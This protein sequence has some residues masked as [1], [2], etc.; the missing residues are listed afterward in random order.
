[1][2][3]RPCTRCGRDAP[4]MPSK[5]E[6]KARFMIL[7]THFTCICGSLQKYKSIQEQSASGVTR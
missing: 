3:Y 6:A 2:N 1:M 7:P 5:E 4:V